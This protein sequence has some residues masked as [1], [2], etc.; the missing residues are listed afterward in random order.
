MRIA[1]RLLQVILPLGILGLAGFA[2]MTMI[3]S[4]PPVETQAP[5]IAPPG[6]RVHVVRLEDTELSVLSEGTVQPRTESQ[7]VPE[8][9]GRITSIAPSFA[10]GGFFEANDV[11]VTI[12][13]FDYRQ[14]VIS[15]RA[16]LAQTRLR[17]AQE[18]AEAEVAQREWDELG[19]GDPRELTLR[20][21]QLEDARAAV[22]AAE[23]NLV[24]TERDLERAEI[25]A[26]YAGRVRR[27]SVDV[28]QFVT[29]GNPIATIYAVDVAEIRLPLPDEDLAYLDLPLSYRGQTN[30][31]GPQVTVSTTFA[32]ETY[33]WAGS[34]V[35]TESEIDPVSRMVNVIAEIRDPYGVGSDPTRPPLAV[36]MYVDAQIAGRRFS[37]I[38]SIP[39][40]A[41]RGR[42]QV[43]VVDEE[44]RLRF[45]DVDILRM[46]T[47]S[48][49]IEAGLETGDQVTI[50]TLD[51]P[52]DGMQVQ[53]SEII[54][55]QNAVQPQLVETEILDPISNQRV[56]QESPAWLQAVVARTSETKIKS[57]DKQQATQDL[58][59][60]PVVSTSNLP[61]EDAN[62]AP[63]NL[64]TV[65]KP[66]GETTVAVLPFTNLSQQTETIRLGE[67]LAQL[68]S[69]QF[70]NLETV[71]IV[72]D[73]TTAQWVVGGA[74]QQEG[75]RLKITSRIVQSEESRTIEVIKVDGHL[76][77]L[78]NVQEEVAETVRKSLQA[79]LKVRTVN[80]LPKA[81]P[82]MRPPAFSPVETPSIPTSTGITISMNP[83]INLTQ[84]PED[85]L[86]VEGINE[87]LFTQITL[88]ETST[89]VDDPTGATFVVTGG[90][91][92]VGDTVRVTARVVRQKDGVVVSS[93]KIDGSTT[94]VKQLREQMVSTIYS[95][96]EA[97]IAGV[98]S[99]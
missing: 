23:A 80:E 66:K 25:R 98:T 40:S 2:T 20:K 9:S 82:A 99:E 71:T 27:K 94:N 39:R 18:E 87:A 15:A 62:T 33:A 4:R 30:S 91:Q 88:N 1:I 36:G 11:L 72:P 76:D 46:T 45:R 24:R 83:F 84:N 44:S 65:A 90:I 77:R 26:P 16:Q 38:A 41:L 60:P 22:A 14:A 8:I 34:I 6:V 59:V 96:L 52:T 3:N 64:E 49:F 68:V 10:E 29:V 70:E 19:Q 50:S 58:N 53:V 78:S 63:E 74:V 75:E 92:R 32:G 31:Q 73:T 67:T 85:T 17:L 69:E 42:N 21:P 47:E 28:G 93:A 97:A 54:D 95:D 51:S 56:A 5:R 37:Q 13:P 79:V 35:R 43:M 48:L 7:L 61:E 12:D 81:E 86:L 57:I 89:F 55:L